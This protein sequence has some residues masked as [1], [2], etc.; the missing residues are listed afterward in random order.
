MAEIVDIKRF[1]TV[2]QLVAHAGIA[3]QERSSGTSVRGRASIGKSGRSRL[4][5]ALYMCAVVASAYDP[6][7]RTFAQRMRMRG[8]PAKVVLAAVM[9]KLLHMVYGVLKS[10][11]AYDPAKAFSR[12]AL[13]SVPEAERAA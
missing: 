4:R 8:K 7:V 11:E 3:P 9:S 1:K 12:V 6:A 13:D 10:Q 2:K 5:K